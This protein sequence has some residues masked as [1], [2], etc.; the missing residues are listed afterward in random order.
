M[1]N[2][3]ALLFGQT[4]EQ[5]EYT[6]FYIDFGNAGGSVTISSNTQNSF[7]RSSD[8]V[9]WNSTPVTAGETISVA[10]GRVYLRGVNSVERLF[11]SSTSSNAWEL[12]GANI[13]LGGNIN[14]LLSSANPSS[15]IL[16]NYTFSYLFRG[17]GSITDASNL[18]LPSSTLS[19]N[20]YSY[21]FYSCTGLTQAPELPATTLQSYCYYGMFYGC[22]GLTQAP[23]LPATTLQ[24]Y[25]YY[26][27]FRDCTGLTQAPELPA[28]TLQS[29]CYFSMF[30][31]CTGLTQAPEL[32]ATT[33][34]RYCYYSM[35][36]GC[37]GL[38]QAP[39]LPATTLQSYCYMSMFQGCSR[40]NSVECLATDI[41][42]FDCVSNW[43][44]NVSSSGTFVKAASMEDWPSGDSGIPTGW[45]V[46]NA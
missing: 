5:E 37:T 33:L 14:S 40:L 36:Q 42:A 19:S 20:C 44:S 32:P 17:N 45:T 15:V 39:E 26:G 6:P 3:K 28:T 24:S 35:F 27:M 30:Q 11:T 10:S 41:S 16:N 46:V 38:T 4:Q 21:M 43:L 8:G 2:K 7:Y 23:E 18:I 25:C 12:V 9:N 13:S 34:Q 1:L 31:D 22:T 29:N